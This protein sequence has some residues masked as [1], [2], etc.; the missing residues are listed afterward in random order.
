MDLSVTKIVLYPLDKIGQQ[1]IKAL[2][3]TGFKKPQLVLLALSYLKD[4]DL[5]SLIYRINDRY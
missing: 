2:E 5:S 1:E 3:K 4:S